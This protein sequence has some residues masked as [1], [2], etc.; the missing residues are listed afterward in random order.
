MVA[1]AQDQFGCDSG[2]IDC[3][4]AQPRFGYGVR[5]CANEACPNASAAQTVIAFGSQYCQ[6]KSSGRKVGAK[7]QHLTNVQ[8]L[9][10]PSYPR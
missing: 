2:D 9:L 7:G 4:C 1:K 8:A 10:L 5:D 3:Y 6:S